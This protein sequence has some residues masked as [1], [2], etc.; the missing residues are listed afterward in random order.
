[1][2]NH[3]S[4]TTS[5]ASGMDNTSMK[6]LEEQTSHMHALVEDIKVTK[7]LSKVSDLD[8]LH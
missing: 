7:E 8:Y 6:L 5:L 2:G 4:N 1:M 3:H